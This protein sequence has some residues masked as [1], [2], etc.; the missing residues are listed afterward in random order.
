VTLAIPNNGF[1]GFTVLALSKCACF[2]SSYSLNPSPSSPPTPSLASLSYVPILHFI[3]FFIDY[4]LLHC[5]GSLIR[6]LNSILSSFRSVGPL[7]ALCSPL[8][9]LA[10]SE[11]CFND[12]RTSVSSRVVEMLR[13]RA[14]KEHIR[15]TR[16]LS[17]NSGYVNTF[18]LL[19]RTNDRAD[20]G[21]VSHRTHLERRRNTGY[22]GWRCSLWFMGKFTTPSVSI[23]YG[24]EF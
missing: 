15:I 7:Y 21:T 22:P 3:I 23:L 5:Y 20:G 19:K 18:S 6:G 1:S 12:A 17:A 14:A 8:K 11:Y 24:V 16:R 13:R 10:S 2:S 9:L 4:G